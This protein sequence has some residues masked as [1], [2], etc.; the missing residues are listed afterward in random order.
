MPPSD[1]RLRIRRLGVDTY[2]E[3]VVYLRGDSAVCRSVGFESQ[4]R[5]LLRLDG[6]SIVATLNVITSDW[7]D[8]DTAGLSEAAWR[9][10]GAREGDFVTLDHPSPPESASDLRAKVYGHVLDRGQYARLLRDAIAGRLSDIELAAF[11][12]ACAGG[13]FDLAENIALTEAM[14]DVGERIEWGRTPVLD[15]H[16][17]GGL[18]GNRTTPI[19]V[20]I[21]AAAGS[22]IPKTSSRAITSP[23]G[24]ADTMATL[25]N[26]DLDL[27]AMRRV[28]ES[29]GGCI[30]WGGAVSLSPADDVLIRVERPLDFDSDAQLT[31]SVLSKKIA[32]GATHVVLDV[33]VGPT[34]KVRSI[35]AAA[36][37]TR[38]LE[39]VGAAIGLRVVAHICDGSQ[40]VGRGIG[41]ALEAW[42]VLRVLRNAADA[43]A[44]LR[45]R[46]LDIAARVLDFDPGTMTGTSRHR[47]DELLRTGAAW[48]KFESICTAQGGL[49]EPPVAPHRF[50]APAPAAGIIEHIDNRKLAKLAKLAGAPRDPSAGLVLHAP[51][52]TRVEAGQPLLT[53]HAES[54]GELEY[55][56][57]YLQKHA[58]IVSV[59]AAP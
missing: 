40:P 57:A 35:E 4:S 23:A 22:L 15:K 7:L 25:T 41:P 18:P 51:L 29:E 43:P 17:V 8:T 58:D 54:I 33:P 1:S 13:Q 46:A 19:V 20:A 5:V 9:R 48:R 47:A 2:Q 10:L 26:V 28:V 32:A 31:A 6:Q 21:V 45:D 16:S 27:A 59:G 11:I 34:A 30:I 24:T 53:L 49:R 39:E 50:D 37:L 38:R 3:S 52:G 36:V 55:A 56:R 42:D 44:D 14:V 12:T